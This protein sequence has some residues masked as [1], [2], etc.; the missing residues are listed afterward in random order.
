V[1]HKALTMHIIHTGGTHTQEKKCP[2]PPLHWQEPWYGWVFPEWLAAA[3][4]AA[5]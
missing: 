4:V 1:G 3:S 5:E 2:L